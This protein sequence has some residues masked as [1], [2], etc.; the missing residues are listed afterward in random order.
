MASQ[1]NIARH[2][3]DAQSSQIDSQ[4]KL[5]EIELKKQEATIQLRQV[6]LQE[7]ELQLERDKFTWERARNEAE[8]QLE[9][10]QQRQV[11]IGDGKVPESKKPVKRAST[12]V[13]K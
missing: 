1:G 8:F 9:A 3:A 13:T 5:A 10:E 11:R 12:P 6:A 7:A 4:V 2:Q